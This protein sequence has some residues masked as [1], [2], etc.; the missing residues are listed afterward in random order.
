MGGK[1][2]T[3]VH[4]LIE[5]I[6]KEDD[7]W[8]I[9][10]SL[11][12]AEISKNLGEWFLLNK[13]IKKGFSYREFKKRKSEVSLSK[14]D[15]EGINDVLLQLTRD[16]EPNLDVEDTASISVEE[17]DQI[18]RMQYEY[19]FDIFDAMHVHSAIASDGDLFITSDE[20]LRSS[21]QKMNADKELKFKIEVTKPQSYISYGKRKDKKKSPHKNS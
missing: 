3:R 1:R 10:N 16:L 21:I 6:K 13:V 20:E 18:L 5:V 2:D 17:M 9:L 15:L 7:T 11:L 8:V 4:R 19:G 12:I 14:S